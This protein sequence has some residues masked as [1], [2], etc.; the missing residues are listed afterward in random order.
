MVTIHVAK[1][2]NVASLAAG[3]I[4]HFQW[5]N[6]PWNTALSYFAYPVPPAATGPHGTR[7]GTV[8]ITKVECTWLRDNYN[9]DSKHVD[10]Y[11]LNSGGEETGFDLY[12]SWIA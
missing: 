8:T 12:E 9:G 7:R 6:P 4:Y 2:G 5:N 11:I 3:A 1:I 10:I